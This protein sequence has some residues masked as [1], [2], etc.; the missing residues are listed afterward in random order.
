MSGEKMVNGIMTI[1]NPKGEDVAVELVPEWDYRRHVI[2]EE[3]F[4]EIEGLQ[5]EMQE[6]SGQID[7][8]ITDYLKKSAKKAKVEGE[9]KGNFELTNFS[10]TKKI[11]VRINDCIYFDERLNLA[12]EKI[13]SCI[14]RWSSENTN[15]QGR[16]I[17]AIIKEAFNVDKKGS[18]NKA[19]ILRLLKV[20]INDK[21]WIAAQKLIKDSMQISETKR[22]KNF[23][24]KESGEKWELVNLNFNT[25]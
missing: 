10:Q 21:E 13:D 16:Y 14:N 2:V 5:K 1:Q 6:L 3:V 11:C 9:W 23:K 19:Q 7:K 8:I 12:K 20:N 25:Y 4:Q 18:V 22:Y 17:E 24:I 15:H